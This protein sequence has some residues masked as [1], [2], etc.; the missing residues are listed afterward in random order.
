MKTLLE[1]KAKIGQ[2]LKLASFAVLVATMTTACGNKGGGGSSPQPAPVILPNNINSNFP[3]CGGSSCGSNT[4]FLASAYG[5]SVNY[6]AGSQVEA[7]IALDFFG[8]QATI[9]ALN[10]PSGQLNQTGGYHGTVGAQG[11]FRMMA[12]SQLCGVRAGNYSIQTSQPGQ[13]GGPGGLS[14]GGLVLMGSGP[15]QIQIQI[16]NNWVIPSVS[17]A[18][19]PDGRQYPYRLQNVI[20][21]SGPFA[22][23]P[24]V[25]VIQ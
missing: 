19:G 14:F 9:A 24:C 1:N 5:T 4:G 21:V 25:M 17:P 6:A 20:L 16:P 18:A 12:D 10:S 8:D 13:W 2:I 23:Q 22:I 3:T 15:S 7:D 11:I